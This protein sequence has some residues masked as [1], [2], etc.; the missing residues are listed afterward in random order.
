MLW[1]CIVCYYNFPLYAAVLTLH[2]FSPRVCVNPTNWC[3]TCYYCTRGD[4]QFCVNEAM[5]T[6]HG[7]FKDGGF[8]KYCVISSFLCFKLPPDMS[9]KQAIFC[10]PI[11]EVCRGWDNM[12]HYESD[13][14]ILVCGAGESFIIKNEFYV[15]VAIEFPQLSVSSIYSSVLSLSAKHWFG[16]N[17][18]PMSQCIDCLSLL[19][20]I[21]DSPP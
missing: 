5:H 18:P 20:I 6:A 2:F 1:S 11:S 10:Q 19:C 17:P 15:Y 8:Q 16:F 12:A 4:P 13:S 3:G 21:Q 7:F 9:L 14:K